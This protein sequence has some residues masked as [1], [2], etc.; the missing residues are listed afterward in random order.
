VSVAE[1]IAQGAGGQEATRESDGFLQGL[2]FGVVTDN[3]D[4][5]GLGRVRIRLP[6]QQESDTS[7]WARIAAPMAGDDRGAYFL[8]EIDDEVVVGAECGDP[9]RL[10]VLGSLWNGHAKPPETNSDGRNDR[11]LIKSRSGHLLKFDDGAE[12]AVEL[13][14]SDGKKLLLDRTGVTVEDG[15]GN[16]IVID[17]NGSS[18]TIESAAELKIKSQTVSIEAGASLELKASG[19]LT[20]QGALVRIN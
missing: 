20:I 12:P 19:T 4:P 6:H 14:L 7:F 11:R 10:I 1:L 8:P 5:E 16:K 13:A 18:M 15:K 9:T 2:A 3:Q 17:S